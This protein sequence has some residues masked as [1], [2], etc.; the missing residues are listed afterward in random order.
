M[1]T[2]AGWGTAR[3][4]FRLIRPFC[5]GILLLFVLAL[6]GSLLG[7]CEPLLLKGLF[8][9]MGR[10][11]GW[12]SVALLAGLLAAIEASRQSLG[13]LTNWLSWKTRLRIHH[14]LLERAVPKLHRATP[15]GPEAEGVGA[16]LTRLDRGIQGFLAA[17]SEVVLSLVPSLLYLAVSAFLMVRLDARLAILSLACAPIP[18]VLGLL[19][20]TRQTRRERLLLTRWRRIYSRLREVLSGISTVRSFVQED[21]ERDKFLRDVGVANDLVVRGVALD[22]GIGGLQ[23]IVTAIARVAVLLFG[24]ALV[25]RGEITAGTVVA[26]LSYLAGLFGPVRGLSGLYG[27]VHRASASLD[28]LL[29]IL[30]AP[31]GVRDHPTAVNLGQVR[32]RVEFRGVKFEYP[33]SRNPV[34]EGID[35]IAEPG[36]TVALVGPSGSG[37]STLMSLLQRFYDPAEG[38]V[39]LD[40]TDLRF[41]QQQSLRRRIGVVSQDPFL[42]DDTV[43]NN[44]AYG[45][46]ERPVE[47]VVEVAR[48]AQADEF[49]R[50]LPK[51]YDTRIGESGSRLSGGERQRLAIARALYKDPPI[52]IF[53]E[54][55]SALDSESE[56][57]VQQALAQ[58]LR[59]RTAFVIAHRLST[60]VSAHRILVLKE[61]RIVERGRHDEL[62]GSRSYYASLVERQV[63]GLLLIP[64][65]P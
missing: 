58:L 54:A 42:F 49:I 45:H 32:G 43:R 59:G 55:T 10:R 5:R 53:D 56:A 46:P 34:L 52:L 18:A 38:A 40:G 14:G 33:G 31:E 63:N 51:G 17:Y 13:S 2:R 28:A 4:G 47:A 23:G 30:D 26:F 24:A 27:T 62:V 16:V 48:A 64:H 8:D 1:Q 60:V 9:A 21:R 29:A 19:V 57:L 61:G 25:S 41:L 15:G 37:K 22:S 3:R 6:F 12:E 44:I 11:E 20:V 39:L 65:S 36:E 35:L 50:R 7:I